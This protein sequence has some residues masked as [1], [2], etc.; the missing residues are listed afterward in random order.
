M[1]TSELRGQRLDVAVALALGGK[2]DLYSTGWHVVNTDG[3]YFQM[4]EVPSYSIDWG[5]MGAIMERCPWLLPRLH[6]DPVVMHLGEFQASTPGGFHYYGATP[7][8]AAA[9]AFVAQEL[10]DVVSLPDNLFGAPA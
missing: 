9:R 7:L 8:V 3:T 1:K 4:R 6:R 2:L 10:G 5:R